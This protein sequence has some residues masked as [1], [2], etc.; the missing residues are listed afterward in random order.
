MHRCSRVLPVLALSTLAF[1]GCATQTASTAAPTAA[2]T[3]SSAP[4]HW[5][6][7]GSDGPAHWAGLSDENATCGAG[8][9]QSPIDLPRVGAGA[10]IDLSVPAAVV[11][12]TTADNG[13]TVQLTVG[14]GETTVVDGVEYH[15]QQLHFH[16]G[17]EHTVQG[18]RSPLELHFVHAD[19]DGNLLVI[20]V[21]GKIG[22]DNPAFDAYVRGAHGDAEESATVDLG[23]MLPAERSY[24]SYDG[25][26]TTPPC[27]EGV[28][29][30]VL[31]TPV[32]LGQEQVDALTE[33]HD[34]NARPTQALHGRT[35]HSG[36]AQG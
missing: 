12:G 36:G 7:Q 23:R 29:W 35:V 22:A 20:G 16:A 34:D 26:L 32:E 6:Y 28:R 21:F 18:E 11:E 14:D 3:P 9:R 25:S 19:A 2:P 17:S 24:W 30:V 31:A 1:T 15:L 27:T 8:Q 33:A 4:A 13:H 5:G 10:P